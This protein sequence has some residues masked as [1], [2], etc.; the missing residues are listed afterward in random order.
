MGLTN[1]QKR[2]LDDLKIHGGI[3]VYVDKGGR[4][5]HLQAPVMDLPSV[6][7]IDKSSLADKDKE[8]DELRGHISLAP[9]GPHLFVRDYEEWR[10][11]CPKKPT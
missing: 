7:V 8:I 6:K 11:N 5:R 9:V 1:A 3:V 4:I 10:K 2:T